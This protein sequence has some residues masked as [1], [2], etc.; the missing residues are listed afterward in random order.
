VRG[1]TNEYAR[2]T[3]AAGTAVTMNLED[4]HAR[5]GRL[6]YPLALIA[7]LSLWLLAIQAP[8]WLDETLAYWQISGGFFKIWGRSAQMPSSFTYLYI[9]WLAK[10]ILG[11]SE[12]A[13]RIPSMLAML[14]AAYALFRAAR[15][16]FNEEIAYI[17]T[18]LFCIHPHLVFAVTDARPYSFALLMT[19]L[20]ILTF[21]LW[22]KRREMRYAIQFGAAAAGILY[23]HYLFGVAIFPAF[24]VCY[25]LIRRSSIRTDLRQ[26]LTM[27]IVFS[28][29]TLPHVI[30]VMG[31]YEARQSHIV[32]KLDETRVIL[33]TLVPFKLLI[34]FVAV[35]FIAALVRKLNVP[36]LE[37]LSAAMVGLP[38]AIVPVAILSGIGA[39]TPMHLVTS[40][41]CLAGVPGSVLT[42]GL[43]TSRV[44]SRHLRQIFCASFVAVTVILYFR[45][46]YMR[47]H[48]Y[49]WKYALQFANNN[50]AQ[51]NAPL[52][53]SSD[54]VE[55]N[56]QPLPSGPVRESALFAPLSYYQVNTRVVPLPEYMND[57]AMTVSGQ[58]VQES[59]RRHQRFLALVGSSHLETLQWVAIY[60]S[61]I[62]VMHPL[63]NFDGILV[64]EFLPLSGSN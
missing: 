42:W 52:V 18:I 7:T 49:T 59:A 39:A 25:L 35:I 15:E 10:S 23:F 22:I 1:G 20:A 31:L 24:A 57:E 26:L 44:D 47:M 8:L 53:I 3:V 43:L 45:S 34:A 9:L 54:F 40:R 32:R 17:S 27:A 33:G 4:A 5:L 28:L 41:Y 38:L 16:L 48:E 13:L 63:G 61:G 50:A 55:S 46:P 14:G 56:Y 29:L 11:S 6:V 51:D 58:F 62:F 2:L 36:D 60:S 21:I 64:V 37:C 12:V 30:R 19:N